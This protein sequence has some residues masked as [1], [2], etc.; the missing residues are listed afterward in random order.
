[1]MRLI[2]TTIA[3]LAL[4]F[5]GYFFWWNTVADT[6]LSQVE[7]WKQAKIK[8]G[9]SIEHSP[10]EISGFPYRVRLDLGALQVK[11]P[12]SALTTADSVWVVAQPWSL[13]HIIFGTK[14][15]ATHQWIQNSVSRKLELTPTESVGS[16]TLT[17]KGKLKTLAIDL[18][19]IQSIFTD[20]KGPQKAT[21]GRF[22][23]H[24]RQSV[25][26]QKM[27]EGAEAPASE[28]DIPAWQMAVRVDDLTLADRTDLPLGNHISHAAISAVVEGKSSDFTSKEKIL[29]WRDK[30]GAIDVRELNL[31]WGK[32]SATAD[33]NLTL[34]TE[35]R[36]LGAFRAKI[37]GFNE[38][39]DV[40]GQAKGLDAKNRLAAG[41]ALNLIAKENEKG[42]RYLDLP[43]SL[44]NGAAYLGPVSLTK[45]DPI[46]D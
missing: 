3:I 4:I 26:P 6:A 18:K 40:F 22:Q 9:Y 36:P 7:I 38:L 14:G 19:D 30:G 10:I 34:D 21:T 16:A 27:A 8:E 43:I 41:F 35:N 32:S 29:A 37:T 20:A 28:Q 24:V 45:L 13:K 5:G 1:M 42:E 46:F 31:V 17:S 23:I 11:H 44:Q 25:L 15:T 39:L 33:G 12:N 2:I